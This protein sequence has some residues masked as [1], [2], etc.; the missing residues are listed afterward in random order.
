MLHYWVLGHTI[1]HPRPLISGMAQTST[2]G[3]YIP[4]YNPKVYCTGVVNP[5]AGIIRVVIDSNLT[6]LKDQ[7]WS[8][9]YYFRAYQPGPGIG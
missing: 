2:L 9:I 1:P 4:R 3:R 7:C 8:G 5:F 6:T